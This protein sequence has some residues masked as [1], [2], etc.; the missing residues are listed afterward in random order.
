LRVR[1]EG[2]L[3]ARARMFCSDG[4]SPVR[5]RRRRARTRSRALDHHARA[6]LYPHT[7]HTRI[8][9]ACAQTSTRDAE[10]TPRPV[11]AAGEFL[12][13]QPR[14]LSLFRAPALTRARSSPHPTTTN[15]TCPSTASLW[16]RRAASATGATSRRADGSTRTLVSLEL[17][18]GL[19][20]PVDR[21]R[22]RPALTRRTPPTPFTPNSARRPQAHRP[23]L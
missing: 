6:L 18:D 23:Q 11:W 1:C 7:Q 9:Y 22:R 16:R 10:D 19:A 3:S 2:S 20:P 15:R 8:N 13:E 21:T 14:R 12:Q 4:A 17:D 5:S